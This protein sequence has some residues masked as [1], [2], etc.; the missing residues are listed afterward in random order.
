VD[1]KYAFKTFYQE[2]NIM[3]SVSA[4]SPIVIT[5]LACC[6]VV[7]LI[8]YFFI[9]TSPGQIFDLILNREIKRQDQ[10]YEQ[11][12]KTLLEQGVS[13]PADVVKLVATG[14]KKGTG[15][16][17]SGP[18]SYMRQYQ[19]TVNVM[20]DN[21]PPFQAEFLQYVENV[22]DELGNVPGRILVRYDPMD[23]NRIMFHSIPNDGVNQ[24]RAEFNNLTDMND[25]IRK[26]G[27]EADAVII[28]VED[29]GLDYPNKS[30]RAMRFFLKV[31]P[32]SGL[33]FD[34]ET[35]ALI[36]YTAMEKYSEGRK[37][38]VKFT[39]NPVRVAF[40]SERNKLIPKG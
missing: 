12:I 38:F 18:P 11:K 5:T 15:R 24:R 1:I 37:L 27:E 19:Y 17:Q 7:P 22:Y 29:L 10:E 23:H 25:Q 30:G 28:K 26:I 39:Q 33:T 2:V 14:T 34:A 40:D 13:A 16:W 9:P 4:M 8:I 21:A 20:P 3:E 36:G 6:F 35:H 32:K 31:T